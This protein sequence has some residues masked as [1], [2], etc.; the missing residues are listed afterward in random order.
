VFTAGV[1][2]QI[3]APNLKIADD[4]FVMPVSK[5]GTEINVPEAL[6][7]KERRMHLAAA[8]LVVDGASGLGF[9]CRFSF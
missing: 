1:I 3:L 5:P 2:V 7:N 8:L 4:K 6:V 9:V